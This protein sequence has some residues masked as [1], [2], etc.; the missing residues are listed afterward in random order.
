MRGFA[1]RFFYCGHEMAVVFF[2]NSVDR[3][4]EVQQVVHAI[5]DIDVRRVPEY[6]IKN[7]ILQACGDRS[8][9][10]FAD[11]DRQRLDD[12]AD[13][14][15][16]IN[17]NYKTFRADAPKPTDDGYYDLALAKADKLSGYSLKKEYRW[18]IVDR[19]IANAK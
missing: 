19:V 4:K 2:G 13:Q 5:K 16:E 15:A 18:R 10:A 14:F 6:E 3:V 9:V 1:V 7:R 17:L 11:S 8:I 12:S